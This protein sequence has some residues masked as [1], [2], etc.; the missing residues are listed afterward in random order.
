MHLPA[1]NSTHAR[2]ALALAICM[3]CTH[4]VAVERAD[5]AASSEASSIRSFAIARQSLANALDQLSAQSGL[6][7]AY[8]SDMAQ[9]IESPGVTGQMT[10]QQALAQ[11]LQ[12]TQLGFEPNGPNA[13]LLTRLPQQT[14]DALEL[15]VTNVTSN[16]LGTVTEG[17]GSYTPGTIATATRLVLTPRETPQSITVITR[18]HMDDFGLDNVDDVMRHTPGITVSAYDTDRTNYYSRG[19][20]INNFQ[21]DGIPSAV[22]NVAYSAGNT[23]SDMA[24]YDRIEVLKGA[25]GLLS[26]AGSLG[27]T[28]NL[29]RKKPTAEAL[30]HITAGAG[31]WDNYR[32]EV[33]LSGP[34][35]EAG[36]VRGR[37][38]AAYQDRHSYIDRYSNKSSVFY[39]IL[40]FDLSPDTMLTVGADYQDNKPEGSTWSGSFPLLNY[41]G[42]I[43]DA[44][45]S[46]SNATDW[47]SWQQYT[48]TVFATL[49]HDMGGGWVTK[50][51]LDHKLN[52]YDAQ[53][54]A[55]QF[56]QPAADGTATINA[57]RYKGETTSDSADLYVSGPFELLGREHD[58]VVGGSISTA[59][60]KGKGYWDE[61]FPTANLVDYFNWHGNLPKPNWGVASQ[62][63]DDTI[64]QTG[65]YLTTRLNLTDDLKLLLGGRVVDYTLTGTTNTYRE[66]GRFIPY[67]GAIY[68]LTDNLSAY[69]SYT[70]VFMPQESYNLDRNGQL[71]DPDEGE[72]Y[73]VG[74]KGEF[75]EGRLNASLAYFEVKESNRSIADDAYNNQTPT[76]PN[77]AFKGTNAKTKG[78]ELEVSGELSPGWQVQGGYTHKVVRD[79]AGEKISTFEPED[80]FSV[81]T[82]YK[83]KG[84]LDKVT[85]GGGARWQTTVWQDIYNSPKQTYEEFSQKSYWVVDLMTRY[86]FTPNL[87]TT[88]NLNNVF[89]KY[90]YTNVGFYNSAI[91]GEPRNFMVTTRWDF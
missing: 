24:I 5:T 86:Q 55:I 27:G 25:S 53:M 76:P 34:L 84:G 91:Y 77:Y 52:G 15:G 8:S 4:A 50:L 29:V 81:Y 14:G 75:L 12:G 87:S 54:G 83:L 43:N 6:Q 56:D 74:L 85:V 71:I 2:S 70:D 78:Y 20:S 30:G 64:R 72:N 67:A 41:A 45:R 63:T 47:S 89:D 26:G 32:T 42:E 7:I 37:A 11:L 49:E 44:K 57:Q 60:W 35:T 82:M 9:G 68:D 39:G 13:V 66:S 88:L 73:E 22:R 17:S 59:H 18:Q 58:L 79:D 61:I 19:F 16:Q 3:A 10:T 80:Q 33:D 46:F 40:E 69:V 36:N 28:I 1:L 62:I 21:Y 90:Y 31:S 51:Q 65:M 23:L 48:R 38:V